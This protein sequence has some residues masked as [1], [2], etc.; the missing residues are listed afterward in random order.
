VPGVA[1]GMGARPLLALGLPQGGEL[2][3]QLVQVAGGQPGQL[4]KEL[5]GVV[6][7][8]GAGWRPR[9]VPGGGWSV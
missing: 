8:L 5:R 7:L 9:G 3:D 6:L 1:G 2:G 4:G